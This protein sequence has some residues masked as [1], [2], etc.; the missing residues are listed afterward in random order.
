MGKGIQGAVL[1]ALGAKEHSVV[2]TGRTHLA[3][4]FIRIAFRSD[5]LLGDGPLHPD[6][7]IRLWF[8][9]PDDPSTLHQRGYTLVDPDPESGT[10][11]IDFVLHHPMG[12]ASYWAGSCEVGERLVAQ[13]FGAQP[14]TLLDPPPAGYLLLGDLASYPAITSIA[15][16]VPDDVPV[17]VYMERH[18]PL[19]ETLPLP[20]GRLV[21]AAWVDEL[22]DG[23]GLA[24]AIDGRDWTGWFA[25]IGAESL[26]TRRAR[27]LL[28]RDH[29]LNKATLH[30]QA[31]W[32]RGRALGKSRTLAELN[33]LNELNAAREAAEPAVRAEKPERDPS[34]GPGRTVP[35]APV[36]PPAASAVEPEA[37]VPVLAPAKRAMW[38]ACVAQVLL[39]VLQ[40][41][42]FILLADVARLLLAGAPPGRFLRTAVTAGVVMG[43]A[44]TGTAVLLTALHVYDASYSA[45]LRRRLMDKLTRLPLG[46]FASR[47]SEEVKRIVGD[48][49]NA[50]HYVVTH[51]VTECVGVVATPLLVLVYL[52]GVQWRLALVLLLPILAFVV[53][54]SRIMKR[55]ADDVARSQRCTAR[56]SAQAQ[57]FISSREEA[58]VLGTSSVV[59]LP[60]T[61]AETGDFI[62]EW[63]MRTGPAKIVAVMLN[64]PTTVLGLLLAAAY[65]MMILGWTDAPELLPFLVLGTSF[66]GRL[67]GVSTS[68]GALTSGLQARDALET[69]LA[70][71]ELVLPTADGGPEGAGPPPAPAP[72]RLA[73]EGVT[74]AYD[75]GHPVLTDLSLSLEP[76]V[77]TA[78]VGPSGA[79]KSTVAALAARLWDP[80]GGRVALGG[81]DLR[82]LAQDDLYARVTILL[83]D[84]QLIR[85]T[86]RDNIALT[87]PEATRAQIEE[88]ARAARVHDVIAAL[89]QGYDTVV[90]S[91]RLSGGERQRLGIARALLADTPVVILD[92]ATASADPDS[93]LQIRQALNTLLKG[94]TVLMIA[95]RLHTVRDAERIVVMDHGRVV[96]TG[97]HASLMAADGVYAAMWAATGP[98]E[99]STDGGERLEVATW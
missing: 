29:G 34:G 46:W 78:L 74:F 83:Q 69:F 52:F 65:P 88:A 22:P 31:Y 82:E 89:P 59:D 99:T 53:V 40:V 63:Q 70:P 50:L 47:G 55:D 67:L 44:A 41:I 32:M 57:T 23:Q 39:S 56:V 9:N 12:P 17:A 38:A 18:S 91:S 54:M 4:H 51:A 86:V 33:E 87:R 7:W 15:A 37:P 66:G 5:T 49:V 11:A 3:E 43:L 6:S 95:H 60:G 68:I 79:G 93:E 64:R 10:F 24:Q 90:D 36:P 92:E 72:D 35:A 8:P 96:E 84:V 76:G 58:R 16:A 81:T 73:L 20:D 45:A 97:T 2:V 85:A 80:Q 25:W 71:P 94:R 61:L 28:I 77:V 75:A 13:R 48:D 42:P 1:R 19:D 26:A 98:P 62:A 21:T 30:A 14:F 27:S